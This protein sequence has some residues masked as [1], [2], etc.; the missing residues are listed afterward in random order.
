MSLLLI[1]HP[2]KQNLIWLFFQI[3]RLKLNLW[4]IWKMFMR[5]NRYKKKNLTTKKKTREKE[6]TSFFSRNLF[7][8]FT[9]GFLDTQHKWRLYRSFFLEKKSPISFDPFG[10]RYIFC[11]S[12]T[13][14]HSVLHRN[15]NLESRGS[16][17]TVP[18][19]EGGTN[20]CD[21]CTN[22]FEF[23]KRYVKF[24]RKI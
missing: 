9:T 17:V 11:C 4:L 21:A 3:F 10:T 24:P 23:F 1:S 22:L 20:K 12:W 8:F 6:Q 18:E 14:K 5:V 16:K 7:N 13:A 15:P 19:K 2:L